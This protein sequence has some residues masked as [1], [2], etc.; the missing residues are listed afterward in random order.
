M[1]TPPPAADWYP[2]PSGKPGL[3]YWDG[4]Q[5]LPR[6]DTEASPP[7]AHP[8][9]A[10]PRTHAAVIAAI[11]ATAVVLVGLVGVTGYLLLQHKHASQTPTA[12]PAPPSS[13]PAPSAPGATAPGWAPFVGHW[14]GGHSGALDIRSDGTGRWT[15]DDRSTCP[16]AGLAGCG[17]AATVDFRLTSLSNGTATG[18]VTAASKPTTD[19]VGEPVTIVLGTGLQGKGAVLAVSISQMQGWG[20]CNKTSPHSCAEN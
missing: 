14:S 5:W 15:Y 17:I 11:V 7:A 16:D 9:R 19:P 2:D 13:V 3:M 4:E 12:Q 1:T 6:P 10:A 8:T 20:F 18:S